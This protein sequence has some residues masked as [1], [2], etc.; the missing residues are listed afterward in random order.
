MYVFY[1]AG[2][3]LGASAMTGALP[4][5]FLGLPGRVCFRAGIFREDVGSCVGPTSGLL[6]TAVGVAW[7]Q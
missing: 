2:V 4:M 7:V 6:G 3:A 1:R 5:V